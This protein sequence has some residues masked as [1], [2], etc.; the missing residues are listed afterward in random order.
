LAP[1]SKTSRY[2]IGEVLVTY[3]SV[4]VT[5]SLQLLVARVLLVGVLVRFAP[6]IY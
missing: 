3:A 6:S 1:M 5:Q 2:T 4:L